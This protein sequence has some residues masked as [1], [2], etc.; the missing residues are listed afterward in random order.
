MSDDVRI[1]LVGTG[2]AEKV[3][4]PALRHVEGARV[5]AVA[6]GH[7]A[8]AERAAAAFGIPRVCDTFEELTSLDE[9]DL[10]VVSSPPHT[11]APAAL[12]ALAAGKHVLCEKPMALDL[13][14][15]KRMAEAAEASS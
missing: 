7:R 13:G 11:H 3:Q 2:F 1:G 12:A 14:E 15:A 8:S 9:V 10:V 6:S 4:L 5:V